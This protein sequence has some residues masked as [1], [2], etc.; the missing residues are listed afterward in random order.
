MLFGHGVKIGQATSR[1]AAQFLNNHKVE[2]VCVASDRPSIAQRVVKLV[3]TAASLDGDSCAVRA[4]ACQVL[5][6]LQ[7]A[8]FQQVRCSIRNRLALVKPLARSF[9][10][11]RSG[12]SHN[13]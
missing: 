2:G 1:N 10:A 11:C 8:V 5:K 12:C 9:I 3:A 13:S 7:L 6:V 4:F